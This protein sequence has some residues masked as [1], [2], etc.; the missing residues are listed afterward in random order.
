MSLFHQKT[1]I[2]WLAAHPLP[3]DLA[4]RHT[5]VL[6]WIAALQ[7]GSLN[8]IKEVS[9]HGQFLGELFQRC[10]GYR[11]AVQGE[12]VA[13][14][15]HAEQAIGGSGSADA[16]LGFFAP[17]TAQIICP[18]EL[19]GAKNDLDRP[20]PGRRE[21]AVEQ[22]WR[23]ANHT[24]GCRWIIVSNYR[25]IRL[26]H[27]RK[28]PAV[29]TSFNLASLA[30]P[31]QFRLFYFLFCR[32]NFL[33]ADP[34]GLSQ[35]DRLLSACEEA[36]QEVTRQLYADYKAVRLTLVEQFLAQ[37][38]ADTPPVIAISAAQKLMDRFL[39]IAFCEDRGLLP[40]KSI[41]RAHDHKDPYHPRPVWENYRAIFRWVDEGNQE[42]AVPRYNG[43]LFAPDPLLDETLQLSDEL[44]AQLKELARFD[45]DS[46]VSVDILGHI[47]E[48]SITDLEEL[49]ALAGGADFDPKKG[50]RKT[51]GVFYTPAWVTHYIVES[52]L[53][54]YLKRRE[55]TL[56]AELLSQ[57]PPSEKTRIA[58]E[59]RFWE[60]YR[61]QAL[62]TT[63][64]LDPACGSGA[65]LIAAFDWLQ[66]EY[67]RVNDSLA[68]LTGGQGSLFDLDATILTENLFGVDLSPES[69]EITRLSLWLKTAQR[70]KP[71]TSLNHNIQ[72]G[73]SIISDT[74]LTP[75]AFDWHR[76][77]DGFDVIIG[78]PPYVRQELL[79]PFKAWLKEQYQAFDGTADLYVYFY[80]LGVRLLKPG[81]LLSYIVTNKWL[82]AGYGEGLRRFFSQQA[83]VEELIDFG[84]APIFEDADTF[85]CIIR[86]GCPLPPPPQPFPAGGGSPVSEPFSPSTQRGED[87]R[88]VCS[89]ES[90]TIYTARVCTIPREQ[91]GS[92]SVAQ[93]VSEQG[94]DVPRSRF[95]AA[96]WSLEPPAVETLMAKIKARG[97]PLREFA[98]V[99]PYRGI[100]TGF[101]EAFLI[102]NETRD[103]LIA[104]D[105]AC[106]AI[107]RPYLRGQDIKRWRP[108][109][110]NQWII[111]ARRGINIEQYPSI[112]AHLEQFRE[113]LEP[114]PKDWDKSQG[115]AWSGRKAGSYKWFELQDSVD[116]W[117]EFEKPKIIYQVIQFHSAYA[118][119]DSG[120]YGNDKTFFIPLADPYLLAVLNS[121]L[122]WWFTWR[123]L[124]HMKDEALNPAGVL[125]EQ[126]PIATPDEAIRAAVEPLVARLLELTRQQ[127][128][129]QQELADWLRLEFGVEK[130]GGIGETFDAFSAALKK[131]LP[132]KTILTPSQVKA[133]RLAFDD[134]APR[135]SACGSE[136][137]TVETALARL[138]NQAYGLTPEEE[139]LLWQTAPPRMPGTGSK[140]T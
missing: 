56:R 116:Y 43:G 40:A 133:L 68:A 48:Q 71:L 74:A 98:G 73:N 108:E 34:A 63:R 81:G 22:G 5:L 11:S 8:E 86:V 6:P 134:Y 117:Q 82:K 129:L 65:F 114:C 111:F 50:A 123:Y 132:K 28:T 122:L 97:L 84:H 101:N 92:I 112:K 24:P 36:E 137:Q 118:L 12:G 72:V 32:D 80:E 67:R 35:T 27:V 70:G 47:F 77:G 138:V 17:G 10:L 16:A 95:G 57:L 113:R 124:P 37:T 119:D 45:F 64:V 7:S 76:F 31:E 104:A 4:E 39:F 126:L 136:A 135:L 44:C 19:K 99:K 79:S 66:R 9:L 29:Y 21:S 89:V 20:A 15:L 120:V 53:G 87:G 59:V 100:L 14:E 61:D 121:P 69:V 38:G 115:R 46:E 90:N 25:E 3:A 58:A 88:G 54:G 51:H 18:I 106:S 75:Q 128:E 109:W 93:Y 60:T 33:A 23:Y 2:S 94:F 107:I 30:D 78:N 85:P 52:T 26:Y 13:W 103:R 105:P 41:A 131:Q 139:Q 140:R 96:P 55:D 102:D 130:F 125:M 127:R 49:K 1:V 110:D 42:M 62:R 91:L 83:L